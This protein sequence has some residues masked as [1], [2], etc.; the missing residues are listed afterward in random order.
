MKLPTYPFVT[1]YEKCGDDVFWVVTSNA[2]QGCVGNGHT[3]KSAMRAFVINE[4]IGLAFMKKHG[5]ELPALVPQKLALSESASKWDAEQ[6]ASYEDALLQGIA[7]EQRI[8]KVLKRTIL[9]TVLE[10]IAAIA[11]IVAVLAV[12]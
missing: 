3:L 11:V 10:I 8:I 1:T 12:R 6:R 4:R 5:H 9:F 2:L 7:Q